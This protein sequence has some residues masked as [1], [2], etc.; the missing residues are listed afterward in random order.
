[1]SNVKDLQQALLDATTTLSE[2]SVEKAK[3]AY[4]IKCT[5]K[6]VENA[7]L[8]LYTVEYGSNV[9][10][11]YATNGIN[12]KEGD[13]VYALVPDGDLSEQIQILGATAP[14]ATML[15]REK[16]GDIYVPISG[17]LFRITN[18][19]NLKSWEDTIPPDHLIVSI[20]NNEFSDLFNGYL[21]N[22]YKYFNFTAKIKTEIDKDHRAKGNYGL[23]LTL[24]FKEKDTL[25]ETTR[26][27]YMDINTMKGNVY[28]FNV[29]ATQNLYFEIDDNLIYDTRKQPILQAFVSG[30]EYINGREDVTYDIHIKDIGFEVLDVLTEEESQGTALRLVSSDGQYFLSGRYAAS[31]TLTPVLKI[32]G[33]NVND[34]SEWE[35]Y[36]FVEDASVD[37]SSDGYLNFGGLGWKC[38]NTKTHITSDD[39]GKVSYQYITNT[40]KWNVDVQDVA[41]T[42]KYKCVLI[43]Y[44]TRTE[45]KSTVTDTTILSAE[46][47]LKNLDSYYEIELVSATGSNY[48]VENIGYVSLIARIRN[49]K[50]NPDPERISYSWQRF[51]KK[52]NYLD[53]DFFEI[54]RY[55]E[56]KDGWLETEIKY[57]CSKLDKINT[58]NCTFYSISNSNGTAISCNL[59]TCSIV[60]AT[61]SD[62]KYG[63]IVSGGDVLY[64]Y[65]SNGD[66]PL[67]STYDGPLSSKLQFI[68]PLSY[69]I[70]KA[71]GT[72]LTE[73]EYS[74]CKY[75]WSFPKNS[76]MELDNSTDIP[77]AIEEFNF[78]EDDD[79]YYI[80]GTGNKNSL[81]YTILNTFN[82]RR[83]NNTIILDVEFAGNKLSSTV[84]PK[85]LKDGESGTNGT[86]YSVIVVC[87]ADGSG[88]DD[89]YGY[90]ERDRYGRIRKLQLVYVN[91]LGW[92]KFNIANQALEVLGYP[93]FKVQVYADGELVS[94]TSNRYEVKWEMFDNVASG[95][96]LGLTN[97]TCF[98]IN[99]D[100]GILSS[101]TGWTNST[102]IYTNVV[103]AIVTIKENSATK[104]R[105]K[106]YAYYPLEITRVADATY[107]NTLGK[108]PTLEGGF[109]CVLYG[110]DGTNPEYDSST[111]FTCTDSLYNDTSDFYTYEWSTSI[112]LEV[113]AASS[114][115][116][117]KKITP[118]TKYD[119]GVSR[120]YIKVALT[121]N[122]ANRTKIQ[123]KINTL[124][125][126]ITSLNSQ[127][128]STRNIKNHLLDFMNNGFDY[129]NYINVLDESKILLS[130]RY[131]SIQVINDLY[132]ILENINDYCI[133]NNILPSIFDYTGYYQ[134]C[135]NA[136]STTKNS[137][138]DLISTGNLSTISSLNYS[139][140]ELTE[141]IEK[142]IEENYGVSVYLQLK[143]LV[144]SWNDQIQ[145]NYQIIYVKLVE[146]N[147]QVYILQEELDNLHNNLYHSLNNLVNDFDLNY[148]ANQAEEFSNLKSILI[149]LY[150]KIL[151][152]D[153]QLN[154]YNDIEEELLKQIDITLKIYQDVEYQTKYYED[155]QIDL[156]KQLDEKREELEGYEKALLPNSINYIVHI[157]PIIMTFNRLEFSHLNGWDGNK[158][159]IDDENDQ[160]LFMPQIG[161]GTKENDSQT[162]TPFFTGI[163]MGVRDFNSNPGTNQ[164]VGLFGL[165]QGIQSIFLN[166]RDGSAIFGKPKSGGQIILDPSSDKAFIYSDNYWINYNSDGIPRSYDVTNQ[167]HEGTCFNITDGIIHFANAEG[168]IYSGNHTTLTS[169]SSVE[170]FYLSH[171]GL[172]IGNDF[173]IYSD[174][175]SILE[176]EGSSLGKWTYKTVTIITEDGTS[177]EE[178]ALVSKDNTGIFLDSPSSTIVMGSNSGRIYSGQHY[179]LSSTVDGFY[180]SNQGLSIGSS[181]VIKANGDT[182]EGSAFG[183]WTYKTVTITDENGQEKET[184]SLVSKNNTGIFLDAPN[185]IIVLGSNSGK[186]YSGQ[187]YKLDST[188]NGFYLSNEGL[189]IGSDFYISAN[190]ESILNHAGSKIGRW[191]IVKDDNNNVIGLKSSDNKGILM[192]SVSSLIVL[193]SDSGKIYS[194]NHTSLIPTYSTNGFYLS[195]EGL[196]IGSD[197]IVYSTGESI[198]EH[199]GSSIGKWKVKKD[200]NGNV[201]G[202]VSNN[203][204]GILMDSATSLIAL[205]SESGKIYSGSHYLVTS[206]SDG[207]YLSHNGLSIGSKV[208]IS[209]G[210]LMRLGRGAVEGNSRKKYWTINGEDDP[211][212]NP[213]NSG[214]GETI[215]VEE[216]GEGDPGVIAEGENEL[217]T[218]IGENSYISYGSKGERDSVYIG[219]DQITLGTKFFVD[220]NGVMRLGRGAVKNDEVKKKYWTINGDDGDII[221][222]NNGGGSGGSGEET[223]LGDDI[224][225]EETLAGDTPSSGNSISYNSYISYGT[226]GTNDSVY[227]GTDKITLGTKFSVDSDGVLTLGKGAVNN[228]DARHWTIDASDTDSYITYNRASYEDTTQTNSVYLGTDGLAL[229]RRF[230][231][232]NNGT[233]TA[234]H[235][236]LSG[237]ITTTMLDR[238]R[239]SLE[240]GRIDFQRATSDAED[241]DFDSRAYIRTIMTENNTQAVFSSD[242][243]MNIHSSND[244]T[245]D[246]DE[247]MTIRAGGSA[248]ERRLIFSA[249]EIRFMGLDRLV[250]KSR[251]AFSGDSNGFHFEY[252]ICTS[253][254]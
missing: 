182:E 49:K 222:G 9:F 207:F 135:G 7:G 201:I 153:G 24:P 17:D 133:S 240:G 20:N 248:D 193:G 1:M 167:T 140:I 122:N 224:I 117:Q 61:S 44:E 108:I 69:K 181:F 66:S 232:S 36:W 71:N 218:V 162:E 241:P 141:T 84:T 187:H 46:I 25:N 202:L 136:L 148:L 215:V 221:N 50:A 43:Q 203:G 52:D 16:E 91:G 19:I 31:K 196:S 216:T 82:K 173:V 164:S 12:Y 94:S 22:G 124:N 249:N 62:F 51:D 180:L 163:I 129:D 80:E 138:Y 171:D 35:C 139:F 253:A 5:I 74:Y 63:L 212:T 209:S 107:V 146:Q 242:G 211:I 130:Y 119:N 40:Y 251:T 149:A 6:G 157:K 131:R 134:S 244:M 159:Y 85:F 86:K 56:L 115:A 114:P 14:R 161:A 106:I 76:M 96:S 38:L 123:N 42:L 175:K 226:K 239:I 87:D 220:S 142:N 231:V 206:T 99:K 234:N 55:N 54:V 143:A 104:S 98:D 47:N 127:I 154:S 137:L 176:H 112:N 235:V 88:S 111:P 113:S 150:N 109:D 204:S 156:Q 2:K 116:Y 245:I 67:V 213:V 125:S 32:N 18:E 102:S 33:K 26:T 238:Y 39:S 23:I 11:A 29:Y 189:S 64:K 13:V 75:K 41:S 53:N 195:N 72:E 228:D 250:V 243:R 34:F 21:E 73:E 132:D 246:S 3:Y 225:E 185:S 179:K 65:D 120:N 83:S 223:L 194:G 152:I 27:Y 174:G 70:Y 118:K 79:Y 254:P 8:N 4:T 58:I 121:M 191:T 252:G 147:G 178:K 105:E 93:Q 57:K 233:L 100:T 166:A 89:A 168:K 165:H 172:S 144:D 30:F 45:G 128:T 155:I 97:T 60:V 151:N 95:Q 37:T 236:N 219:T 205:G 81:R 183:G 184:K 77:G 230:S 214:S 145:N 110:S 170:G 210:G 126:N 192:D 197:F 208:F 59:G 217:T 177:K 160:Y 188:A 68:T 15:V 229:G 78:P 237:I 247:D 200:Y 227:I 186:I 90:G 169:N 198:L 190:G 10:N 158:L 48:F 103:R 199:E 101:T 92:R 28:D